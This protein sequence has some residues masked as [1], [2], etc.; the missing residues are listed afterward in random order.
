MLA[1]AHNLV[2]WGNNVNTDID[3]FSRADTVANPVH[4]FTPKRANSAR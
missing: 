3:G 2:P 1:P 4:G